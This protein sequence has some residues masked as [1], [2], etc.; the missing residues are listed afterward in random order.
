MATSEE[1]DFKEVV[2]SEETYQI[3]EDMD[4]H[5][6]VV[7][8]LEE[9][10]GFPHPD[11]LGEGGPSDCEHEINIPRKDTEKKTDNSG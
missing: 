4:V 7:E 8:D 1:E 6:G 11:E 2:I 3:L 9:E 5:R 10:Y